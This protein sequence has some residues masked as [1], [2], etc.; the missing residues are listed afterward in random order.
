MYIMYIIWCRGPAFNPS[1]GGR[2]GEITSGH[3]DA[4]LRRGLT[5]SVTTKSPQRLN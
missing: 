3:A 5:Q 1:G 2:S 4:E